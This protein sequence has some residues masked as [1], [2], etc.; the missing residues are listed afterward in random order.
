[1]KFTIQD[2]LLRRIVIALSCIHQV[3]FGNATSRYNLEARIRYQSRARNSNP[4]PKQ[5]PRIQ[6][7]SVCFIQQPVGHGVSAA[8]SHYGTCR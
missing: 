4:I 5:H 3:Y 7:T 6:A 1:M 2:L 8:A